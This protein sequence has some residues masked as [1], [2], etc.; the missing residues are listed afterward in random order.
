MATH[1]LKI[2]LQWLHYF[3]LDKIII[4]LSEYN[5][6]IKLLFLDYSQIQKWPVCAKLKNACHRSA[7]VMVASRGFMITS[8]ISQRPGISLGRDKHHLVLVKHTTAFSTRNKVHI[9]PSCLDSYH[10]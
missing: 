1:D 4:E 5:M 3:I 2:T 8:S 6:S 7:A 9:L 10:L